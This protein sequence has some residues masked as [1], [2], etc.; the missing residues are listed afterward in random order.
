MGGQRTKS[1]PYTAAQGTRPAAP[2]REGQA[3]S[4]AAPEPPQWVEVWV[5]VADKS[6]CHSQRQDQGHRQRIRLKQHAQ[7]AVGKAPLPT[8]EEEKAEQLPHQ[9]REMAAACRSGPARSGAPPE[10]VGA[11]H[12]HQHPPSR[13]GSPASSGSD[14]KQQPGTPH[15]H[16]DYADR[17]GNR[18]F[19]RLIEPE[20]RG[21]IS[22]HLPSGGSMI[23]QARSSWSGRHDF[24]FSS[25]G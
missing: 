5:D 25:V 1:H 24:L 22:A 18:P 16:H 9:K 6:R 2:V 12:D 23:R 13:S 10:L 17:G 21:E 19:H 11:S 7:A 8:A 3:I 14:R 20:L 15:H 4:G